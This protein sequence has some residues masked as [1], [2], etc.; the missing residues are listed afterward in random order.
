MGSNPSHFKNCGENCPVDNV[1]W[2]D[3]QVFIAKLNQKDGRGTYRLPTEA[4]WEYAARAGSTG[5]YWVGDNESERGKYGWYDRNS[6]FEMHPV[7]QKRPNAWGLYD[8]HGNISEW[9][10]DLQGEYPEYSVTDPTGPSSHFLQFRVY[11]GGNMAD[12]FSDCRSTRRFATY[13]DNRDDN[14]RGFRLAL[15]SVR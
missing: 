2:D 14:F 5:L 1:S 11:R 4:E 7:G 10:Q 3:T 8:M 12:N 13:Q 6:N 9:C 15:S